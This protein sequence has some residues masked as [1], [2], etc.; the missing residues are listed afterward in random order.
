MW[1]RRS[2]G[3]RAWS[4]CAR[5][6]PGDEP[7]VTL[8]DRRQEHGDGTRGLTGEGAE[9]AEDAGQGPAAVGE[10]VFGARRPSRHERSLE[11]ARVLEL[12]EPRGKRRRRDRPQRLRELPEANGPAVRGP[13]DRDGPAPLEEG[14]RAAGLLGGRRA[15]TAAP[16][17]APGP[18]PK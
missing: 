2:W 1:R 4:C 13:D 8:R 6:A 10:P 12:D 17:A 7:Q 11:H 15:P 14:R 9:G 5:S 18:A 16:G 3:S